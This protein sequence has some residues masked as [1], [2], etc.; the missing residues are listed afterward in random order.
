MA[1]AGG[2]AAQ[3]GGPRLVAD[4]GCGPGHTTAL[5]ARHF[6]AALVVGVDTS[7]AFLSE[8]RRRGAPRCCYVRADVGQPLP[9]LDAD[10]A[11]A[12]FVLA[13]LPS[14]EAVVSSWGRSVTPRGALVLEEPARIDTE[15]VDFR[16]YL[17]LAAAVVSA[18]G[19]DLFVGARLRALDCAPGWE[20]VVDRDV[21]LEVAVGPAAGMFVRNL[22]TWS[23][24]PALAGRVSPGEVE[25]LAARLGAR[26]ADDA[27]GV[28]RWHI[29]QVVKTRPA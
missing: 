9:V 13:H 6:G 14:P 8:A 7:A 15:D 16:R 4:L 5:L 20:T 18:R 22:R 10:V 12:R 21:E 3:D 29:R 27:R 26:L 19:A 1:G 11:Y 17:D 24:D 28:I 2:V 23:G 25:A